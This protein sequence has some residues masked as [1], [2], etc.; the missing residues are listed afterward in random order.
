MLIVDEGQKLTPTYIEVLRN[1]LNYETNE[2]KLLQLVIF[3][4]PEFLHKMKRQ[5]NFL[6]RI[7]MGYVIN[8][9]NVEDTKGI[10]NYR[11]KAAGLNLNRILFTDKSIKLIHTH[12]Q[13]FPRRIEMFCHEALILMIRQN[14]KV[15]D[16][17]FVLNMVRQEVNW[18][19]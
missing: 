11:L 18:H 2:Y 14:K 5:P 6:D 1:L 4:Q 10:I 19:A 7:A 17:K 16:E 13:G 8:P 9:L 3:S 12:T 15:I